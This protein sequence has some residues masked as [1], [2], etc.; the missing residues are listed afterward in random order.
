MSIHL[1]ELEHTKFTNEAIQQFQEKKA[2]LLNYVRIQHV[3]GAGQVQFQ[4]MGAVTAHERTS[5]QTMIPL[6]DT[7]YTKATAIVK[8]YTVSDMT[9]MFLDAKTGVDEKRAFAQY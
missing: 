6:A 7:T 2:D 5:N 4:V 8:D 3:E 9:A 1:S